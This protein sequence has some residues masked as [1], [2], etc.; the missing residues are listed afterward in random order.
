MAE[1]KVSSTSLREK[2]SSFKTI[3]ESIRNYTEDMKK[4]VDNLKS[5][6]EGMASDETRATFNKFLE[7]FDEKYNEIVK[8]ANFLEETASAYEKTENANTQ[9]G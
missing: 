5:S 6:W 9:N 3:A 2:A 7:S 8:Y 1:I 4:T